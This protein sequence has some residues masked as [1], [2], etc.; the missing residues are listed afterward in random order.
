MVLQL[1]EGKCCAEKNLMI[2]W[3]VIQKKDRGVK[4][5][6]IEKQAKSVR[7]QGLKIYIVSLYKQN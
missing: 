4:F 1:N 6:E 7:F 5:Y 2:A 3:K